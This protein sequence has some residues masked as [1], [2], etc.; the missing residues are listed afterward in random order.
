MLQIL[1]HIHTNPKSQSFT[2]PSAYNRD[3]SA[4]CYPVNSFASCGGTSADIFLDLEIGCC[5][6][7]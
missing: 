3:N 4:S 7:N 2:N 1:V 6:E 5:D